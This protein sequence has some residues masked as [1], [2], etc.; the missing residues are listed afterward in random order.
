MLKD[1]AEML[2]EIKSRFPA[3]FRDGQLDRRVLGETVF[4]D[5]GALEDLNNI[6][7]RHIDMQ[8]R[9]KLRQWARSGGTLAAIDA[10]ALVQSGISEICSAVVGVTADREQRISRIMAR[11]K[12]PR[13]YALMRID[14][15]PDDD[16]YAGVCGY[17]L[18]NSGTEQQFYEQCEKI[19]S[20]VIEN[21]D[22]KGR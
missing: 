14:A 20:E 10:V 5:Q 16:Y 6:T 8:V 4:Q 21:G 13:E 22:Q 3:A 2:S 15:Q 11:D 7:H 19:F 12:I 1:D 18:K 9:E 17:M